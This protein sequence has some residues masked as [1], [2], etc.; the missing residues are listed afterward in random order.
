MAPTVIKKRN[1][2]NS[3]WMDREVGLD[4]GGVEGEDIIKGYCYILKEVITILYFKKTLS[5]N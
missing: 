2:T 3:G 1:G 4:L 5:K